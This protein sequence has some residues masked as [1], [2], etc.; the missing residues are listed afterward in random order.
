MVDSETQTLPG[1]EWGVTEKRE[2]RIT[3]EVRIRVEHI[4]MKAGLV[5]IDVCI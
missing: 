4:S 5:F 1:W 2:G 3:Q